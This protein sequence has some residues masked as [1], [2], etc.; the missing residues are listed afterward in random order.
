MSDMSNHQL[1]QDN[2]DNKEEDTFHRLIEDIN[3]GVI[4]NLL[5]KDNLNLM[6]RIVV[7]ITILISVSIMANLVDS[8]PILREA[9]LVTGLYYILKNVVPASNRT[10]LIKRFREETGI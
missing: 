5:N 7:I 4:S 8:I 10:A 3:L 6:L 1:E 9:A 2:L